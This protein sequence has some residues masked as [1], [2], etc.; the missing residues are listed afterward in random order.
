MNNK[1]VQLRGPFNQDEELV[2]KIKAEASDFRSIERIGICARVRDSVK[3]NNE[4]FEIGKTG[5]LQFDNV[6]ITSIKFM[7]DENESTFVD[8]VLE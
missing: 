3:L 1:N 7:Q 4:T 5:I 8:C 6:R 2:D